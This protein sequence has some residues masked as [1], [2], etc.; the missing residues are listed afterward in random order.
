MSALY[1]SEKSPDELR[2][3]S[4][5]AAAGSRTVADQKHAWNKLLFVT[6]AAVRTPVADYSLGRIGSCLRP[7]MVRGPGPFI[8]NFLYLINNLVS[9]IVTQLAPQP[10][11]QPA[12]QLFKNSQS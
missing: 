9:D 1:C 2:I 3:T 10:S 12:S 11:D 6:T 7:G 4:A 5:T 8:V